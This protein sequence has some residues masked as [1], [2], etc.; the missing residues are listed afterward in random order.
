[1]LNNF[2]ASIYELGGLIWFPEFSTQMFTLGQYGPAGTTLLITVFVILG[3]YYLPYG[4]PKYNRWFHWLI[5]SIFAALLSSGITQ[6]RINSEFSRE[7]LM[8]FIDGEYL[9]LFFLWNTVL[10]LILGF[11]YSVFIKRFSR[12]GS[13]TPV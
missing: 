8:N 4:S 13:G 6:N 10:A 2:F 9:V 11:C 12:N 1:M 3:I 5:I 7:G